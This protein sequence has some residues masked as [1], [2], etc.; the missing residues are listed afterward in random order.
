MFSIVW[1]NPGNVF[2][3]VENFRRPPPAGRDSA[4][5]CPQDVEA[6]DFF[7][8]WAGLLRGNNR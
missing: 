2:H 7:W 6:E 5:R 4:A 1:K 3:C 8:I